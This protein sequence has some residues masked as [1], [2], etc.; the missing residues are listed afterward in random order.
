MATTSQDAVQRLRTGNVWDCV[1][2]TPLI[3]LESLSKLTGCNIYGK[4]EFLN[5]GGSVKDRAAKGLIISMEKRGL[6][7]GDTIVEGTAGNTGIGLATLAAERGY[8]LVITMPETQAQ[9]KFDMLEMLG[10]EVV[11]TPVVPFTDDRH[12]YHAARILAEK[13]PSYFWADQFENV[14]NGDYHYETTGAEI[15]EQTQGK[16]DLFVC[17]VGSSG[18]MSGVSRYLKEHKSSV[19]CIVADPE[20]AS[21]IYCHIKTGKIEGSGS[22]VTE[23]IGIMRITNNYKQ[24]KVD[25]AMRISDQEMVD[26][27]YHLSKHDGL[28]LGT[29][30]GVNA[31]AAY[32]LGQMNAGTGKT[33][34]TILCDHG[35]RYASRLLNK[36][37]LKEKNLL[38]RTLTQTIA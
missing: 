2:N 32:R 34:V 20:N 30:S 3:K 21:G 9:E 1:G 15:W 7:R 14:S 33:I 35:S 25:D 17:A 31:M 19:Q 37:W 27:V 23:G 11:K 6:K 28:F 36:E 10:A 29:S 4:A 8:R 18:T 13:N 26:M 16:I 12:F 5:P 38:P 24:I 22:T